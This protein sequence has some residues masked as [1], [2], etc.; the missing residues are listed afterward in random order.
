VRAE[1]ALMAV[2]TFDA[3]MLPLLRIAADGKAHTYKECAP[4]IAHELQLTD[5]DRAE[6]IPSGSSRLVNRSY[7]AKLYLSQAKAL[8]NL[9]SGR[10][11]ITQRGRDLLAVRPG[12]ISVAD[13]LQYPEFVAFKN[14]SRGRQDVPV[15]SSRSV[16]EN[17]TPHATPQDGMQSAYQKLKAAVVVELLET[18]RSADPILLSQIMVKLLLAMGYGDDESGVVLDGVNDGGV[19]GF[20]KKDRLGLSSVYIQAKRYKDGNSVGAPAIQQFAGSMQERR[21]DEG[22]FVTTSS[23]TKAAMESARKLQA[24]IA[25][26]DGERLAEIMYELGVGVTTEHILTLKRVDNDFFAAS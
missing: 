19:D 23:F 2:P 1:V 11:R 17:E 25:L 24:R 6:T 5:A 8:E 7:W 26:I 13:L 9:G 14:K 15:A 10:F 12:G 16:D 20:V 18:V 21:A 3:L 4:T 22:V